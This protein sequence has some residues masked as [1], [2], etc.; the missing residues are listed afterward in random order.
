M[1]GRGKPRCMRPGGGSPPLSWQAARHAQPLPAP[2]GLGFAQPPQQPAA[3]L[4]RRY[5][6][7]DK[8]KAMVAGGFSDPGW[9]DFFWRTFTTIAD[10]FAGRCY[11]GKPIY[12]EPFGEVGKWGWPCCRRFCC[13]RRRHRRRCSSSSPAAAAAAADP[14]MEGLLLRGVYGAAC[15]AWWAWCSQCWPVDGWKAYSHLTCPSSILFCACRSTFSCKC[16]GRW[17]CCGSWAGQQALHAGRAA[18]DRRKLCRTT[19]L[20]QPSGE[21]AACCSWDAFFGS[22]RAIKFELIKMVY[23]A[24][25]RYPGVYKLACCGWAFPEGEWRVVRAAWRE[26][27]QSVWRRSC[28]QQMYGAHAVAA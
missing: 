27:G 21:T 26:D 6:W 17:A 9:R 20:A 28:C 4:H 23:D 15:R 2:I 18:N 12:V 10:T 25:K 16:F 19:D 5:P 13:G 24:F 11:P 3:P 14:C 7:N 1:S 22:D 8:G